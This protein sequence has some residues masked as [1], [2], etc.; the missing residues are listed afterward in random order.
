MP[1]KEQ[2]KFTTLA[3]SVT[4]ATLAT[5]VTLFILVMLVTLVKLY[6]TGSNV[7]FSNFVPQVDFCTP[8]L[9]L[10]SVPNIVSYILCSL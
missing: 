8:S 3:T 7:I 1:H 9:F 5:S 4:S 2:C 10:A 6:H